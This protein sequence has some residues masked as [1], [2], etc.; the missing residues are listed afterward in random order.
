MTAV[1]ESSSGQIKKLLSTILSMALSIIRFCVIGVFKERKPSAEKRRIITPIILI[2]FIFLLLTIH[3][4][5][6]LHSNGLGLKYGFID[7]DH[8][9]HYL[10]FSVKINT[11][12]LNGHFS[13]KVLYLEKEVSK[14]VMEG[15]LD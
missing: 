7:L 15:L 1:R 12:Q 13:Q 5:E 10:T 8:V 6:L 3:C 11:N 4:C 9:T 2:F 14:M